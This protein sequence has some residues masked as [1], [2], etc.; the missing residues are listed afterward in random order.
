MRDQALAAL[1]G[2]DPRAALAIAGAGLAVLEG[3]GLRA[4]A[5]ALLVALAEIEECLDRF[6]DA[7]A[8]GA[9]HTPGIR[10]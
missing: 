6:G 10:R 7:A 4:A 5:T 3:A 1:D 9:Y 8:Q 2:G